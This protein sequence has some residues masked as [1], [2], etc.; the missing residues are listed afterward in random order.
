MRRW[1]PQKNSS[2][3]AS[4]HASNVASIAYKDLNFLTYFNS[5]K[6]SQH[7]VSW[8]KE[9]QQHRRLVIVLTTSVLMKLT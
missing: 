8:A 3:T 6:R 7:K 9:K 2:L 4:I 5:D 1:W